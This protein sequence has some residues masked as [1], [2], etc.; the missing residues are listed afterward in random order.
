MRPGGSRQ[1]IWNSMSDRRLPPNTQPARFWIVLPA[2]I[3]ILA[4]T[5]MTFLFQPASYWAE[6]YANRVE[7]SPLGAAILGG[8]P[9]LFAGFILIWILIVVLLVARLRHPWNKAMALAVVAG[10]TA[11]IYGW[12]VLRNYWYTIPTFILVGILTVAC[13]QKAEAAR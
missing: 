3:L 4:D 7:Q 10:H 5:L 12:L 1:G 13:W 11:G 8:H 6:G 9:T 2:V